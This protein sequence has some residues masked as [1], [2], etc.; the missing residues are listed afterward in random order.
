M[1]RFDFVGLW[2]TTA[3]DV[4]RDMSAL[5]EKVEK[6]FMWPKL[7]DVDYDRKLREWKSITWNEALNL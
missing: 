4:E 6:V 3:E 2:K 5:V 7:E 1:S